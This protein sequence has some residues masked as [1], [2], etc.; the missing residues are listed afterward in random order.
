MAILRRLFVAVDFPQ[1]TRHRLASI[2]GS[3]LNAIPGAVVAPENWHITL[4]FVGSASAA[5]EDRLVYE[6]SRIP[7]VEPFAIRLGGFGAFP[8]AKKASVL[9]LGVGRGADQLVDL[10]A[11]VE[12][13]V[14][15][16]GFPPEDRPF[17]P[18][19]TVSRFRP[20]TDL[21]A[22]VTDGFDAGVQLPVD[23]VTLFA[24]ILGP[25]GARY[26]VVDQ[27]EL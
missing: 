10:A 12:A 6:L 5:E 19:M 13:G 16:A 23:A 11:S 18:H 1:E 8:R 9:W 15:A 2:L 7:R 17:R 4:R 27:F 22:L 25:G 3:Q 24:S 20:S 14:Q 21:R 26:E